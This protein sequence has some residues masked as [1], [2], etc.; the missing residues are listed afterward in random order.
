MAVWTLDPLQME[1]GLAHRPFH[2]SYLQNLHE[3]KKRRNIKD[4]L[5][6]IW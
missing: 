3:E 4:K 6:M 5:H 2:N 1:V